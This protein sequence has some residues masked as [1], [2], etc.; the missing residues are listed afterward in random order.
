VASTSTTETW[1]A[2]WTLT[3]RAKRK[4]LTDNFFD[5]YPTLEAFRSSGSLEMETG[6]KE[7]QEDILYS[8]NSAEYFSG[9]DV[10]NTDAVDGITAAFYPFRYASCPITINHIEEMENRKT[11]AAMKLLEAKTQQSMLTL[12]DQ[13]NASIYSAQTG[14]SPLG[15]QDIIA[16]APASSPTTLGG[17]TVSGNSWWKNKTEDAT[18]DTSF[19]TIT[20]TNF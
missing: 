12:R 5:S 3:M 7:I 8:G 1:D 16:N 17:I 9:Y 11:D 19:K 4:T 20:G 10:L 6:G 13:I 2:A 18:S 15:F 14:K